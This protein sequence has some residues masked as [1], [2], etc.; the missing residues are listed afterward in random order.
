[1]HG[2]SQD[3]WS[4]LVPVFIRVNYLVVGRATNVFANACNAYYGGLCKGY[5]LLIMQYESRWKQLSFCLIVERLQNGDMFCF[6]MCSFSSFIGIF[7]IK[8]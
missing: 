3:V 6:R 4:L 7:H 8:I 5:S 1:M 2:R